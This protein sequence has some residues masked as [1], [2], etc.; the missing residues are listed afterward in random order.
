M[1]YL[2]Q[3]MNSDLTKLSMKSDNVIDTEIQN[4]I[5]LKYRMD[6]L[7]SLLNTIFRIIENGVNELMKTTIQ[8]L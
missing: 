3:T 7:E 4:E 6:D 8:K 1:T 2:I 5:R